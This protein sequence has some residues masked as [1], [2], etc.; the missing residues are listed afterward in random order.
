[1]CPEIIHIPG[2]YWNNTLILPK[3]H[4]PRPWVSFGYITKEFFKYIL[5]VMLLELPQFSP[6]LTKLFNQVKKTMRAKQLLKKLF[7]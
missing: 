3:T 6:P 2:I 4:S 5:W 1:M 7:P